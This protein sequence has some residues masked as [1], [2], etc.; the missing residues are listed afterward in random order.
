[1]A[2][3]GP[4]SPNLRLRGIAASYVRGEPTWPATLLPSFCQI[5]RFGRTLLFTNW[6]SDPFDPDLHPAKLMPAVGHACEL[7]IEFVG[8]L[9]EAREGEVTV[10][11]HWSEHV[12]WAVADWEAEARAAHDMTAKFGAMTIQVEPVAELER[13][14]LPSGFLPVLIG[15][16]APSVPP[17]IELPL[18]EAPLLAIQLLTSAE[19]A[20]AT[21]HGNGGGTLIADR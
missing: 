14:A 17:S 16:A 21:E 6:L 9:P 20:F 15:Q 7:W 18:V 19:Y 11:H 10:S 4:V 2:G 13:F 12:L 3:I 8:E 1:M 5:E